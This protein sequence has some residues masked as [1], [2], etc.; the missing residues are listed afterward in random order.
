M[1]IFDIGSNIGFY[2]L[3][4]TTK[5]KDTGKIYAFEPATLPNKQFEK[6]IHEN[7]ITNIKLLPL[8]V[9]DVNG[10]VSFNICDDDAYNSIGS[11]PMKDIIETIEIDVTSIDAFC[12]SEKINKI[13]ILKM[14]AE[15]AEYMILKGGQKIFKSDNAPIIF[16]E[17]N[18]L[19]NKGFDYTLEDY[20]KILSDYGYNLYELKNGS[21]RIFDSKVAEKCDI[22]CL[23]SYHKEYLN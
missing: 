4:A 2:S 14:D 7:N 15:G 1:V 17:F 16:C 18:I 12:E 19:A 11:S 20:R 9:S 10:K 5:L 22:V 23:K 13:D 3:V 6:S 8:G 21:L